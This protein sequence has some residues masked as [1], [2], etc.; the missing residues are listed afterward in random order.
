M[1]STSKSVAYG[2]MISP[3]LPEAW[4]AALYIYFPGLVVSGHTLLPSHPHTR[5]AALVERGKR[6]KALIF[7][8]REE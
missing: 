7:L 1:K 6:S 4:S 3:R 8:E 5:N 2:S